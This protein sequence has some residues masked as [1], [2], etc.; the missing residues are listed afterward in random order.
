MQLPLDFCPYTRLQ[1]L[2]VLNGCI[3]KSKATYAH[4]PTAGGVRVFVTDGKSVF[5]LQ[6]V[7]L[8]VGIVVGR[9]EDS[10]PFAKP[11]A[12]APAL[13]CTGG[14]EGDAWQGASEAEQKGKE[15]LRAAAGE[16]G[17]EAPACSREQSKRQS[18]Q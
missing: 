8:C 13:S 9:R 1:L 10:R 5:H 17:P 7:V 18:Q 4:A 16:D 15:G 14:K 2:F 6:V 12:Q 3:R 11:R